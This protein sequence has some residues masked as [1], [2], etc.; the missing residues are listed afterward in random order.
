MHEPRDAKLNESL[1]VVAHELRDPLAVM[2]YAVHLLRLRG[3][4]EP[5]ILWAVDV[6]DRQL[7]QVM[8]LADD[9]SHAAGVTSGNGE[10]TLEPLNLVEVVRI[11]GETSRPLI[12][13]GG[14]DLTL[15]LPDDILEVMADRVRLYQILANLLTNATKYTPQGGSV[16][17]SAERTGNEA[18]VRVRDNGIGITPDMLSRVFD[19]HTQVD[20]SLSLSQGG[21]GIGL[22][23]VKHLVDTHGG[24]V[25][26]TSGG[27]SCGSEFSVRLPLNSS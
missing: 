23:V 26:A 22:A 16:W 20:D 25:Q 6:I 4:V 17:L 27:P 10:L 12:A 7:T 8:R 2:R 11:A 14:H 19:L 5:E 15:L 9:L 1:S 13:A 18:V 24:S 21:L 3:E